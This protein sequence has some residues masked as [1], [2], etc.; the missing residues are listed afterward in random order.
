VRTEVATFALEQVND[1]LDRLRAGELRGSAVI[2][3]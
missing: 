2:V 3:P 1:A